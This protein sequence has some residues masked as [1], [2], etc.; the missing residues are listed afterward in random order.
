[1]LT[2]SSYFVTFCLILAGHFERDQAPESAAARETKMC[3]SNLISDPPHSGEQDELIAPLVVDLHVEVVV[4]ADGVV[5]EANGAVASR[6][7]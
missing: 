7:E 1:M 5:N 3:G 2:R 4:V 6:I